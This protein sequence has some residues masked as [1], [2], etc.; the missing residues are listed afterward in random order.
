VLGPDV[1]CAVDVR[2]LCLQRL[3]KQHRRAKA[4]PPGASGSKASS[5]PE[6]EAL[7]FVGIALV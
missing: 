5:L 3:P 7:D 2:V 4:L 6:E 1:A